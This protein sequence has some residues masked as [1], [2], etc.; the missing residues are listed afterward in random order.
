MC[1]RNI[2][3]IL[4][5][6]LF[7]LIQN[8]KAEVRKYDCC[9]GKCTCTYDSEKLTL[10]FTPKAGAEGEILM[11]EFDTRDCNLT[12]KTMTVAE[13]IHGARTDGW[14]YIALYIN[15]TA[16]SV[17]KLPS[18]FHT[19][20]A[21]FGNSPFT[22]VDLSAIQ[23]QDQNVNI[24]ISG[25]GLKNIILSEDSD[26]RVS[27][28]Y[29]TNNYLHPN[30]I[31]IECQ[32]TDKSV[33]MG[34]IQN[35]QTDAEGNKYMTIAGHKVPITADYFKGYDNNG[36]YVEYSEKGK[37]VFNSPIGDYSFYDENGKYIGSFMANG[38]K[39]RIYNVDEAIAVV[40]GNKN[41]FS[42]KYQ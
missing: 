13:G 16:D 42:I 17:V 4:F 31:E 6:V 24:S 32:G 29:A 34:K 26:V 18:T 14:G 2:L 7:G 15:A 37:K 41:T 25:T 30:N 28:D 12:V 3:K 33:C 11:S 40:S 39:R 23:N 19:Q 9:S 8:V 20:G 21:I 36:E 5:L 38:Q 1:N 35:L 22:T 27:I 10:D